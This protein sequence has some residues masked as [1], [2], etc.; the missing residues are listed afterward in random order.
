[1]VGEEEP[2]PVT[3]SDFQ[4]MPQS[5]FE[6]TGLGAVAR[7]CAQ[8]PLETRLDLGRVGLLRVV[9]NVGRLVDPT[10]SDANGRPEGGR[11]RQRLIENGFQ[12][13]ELFGRAPF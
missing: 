10:V 6:G 2:G 9:E 3:A 11:F 7:E 1:M 4:E 13:A 5:P 12:A 8:Q